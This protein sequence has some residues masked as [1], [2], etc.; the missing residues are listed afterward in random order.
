MSSAPGHPT[1]DGPGRREEGARQGEGGRRRGHI[2][3]FSAR[4]N[5]VV[6]LQG[7]EKKRNDFFREGTSPSCTSGQ[8]RDP[9]RWIR[10]V[11]GTSQPSG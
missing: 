7:M 2:K 4:E 1:K 5:A 9:S 10:D 3:C 8:L 11:G 6:P